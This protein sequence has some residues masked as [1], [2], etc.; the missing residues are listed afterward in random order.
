MTRAGL[1]QAPRRP[2]G[3]TGLSKGRYGRQSRE[4]APQQPC[5]NNLPARTNP[6]RHSHHPTPIAA[7]RQPTADNIETETDP[8]PE[9]RLNP[10]RQ[11]R[12]RDRPHT[13]AAPQPHRGPRKTTSRACPG[14]HV[15]AT[16][17]RP[18]GSCTSGSPRSG[19]HRPSA[20]PVVPG[21]Q[22]AGRSSLARALS[23]SKHRCR[24]AS[25]TCLRAPCP[26]D[27]WLRQVARAPSRTRAGP[28]D[29]VRVT[30][31]SV[32]RAQSCAPR[33][34]GVGPCY[35]V[36]GRR[37]PPTPRATSSRHA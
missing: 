36:R 2:P 19:R 14:G 4:P 3:T 13:R 24:T 37:G 21:G 34:S 18:Q 25:A 28:C 7:Q 20:K 32:A 29:V 9:P 6:T 30:H 1:G 8:R 33:G 31:S 17:A 15:R 10:E 27:T 26:L 11:H 35:V 5:T 12:D 16:Q 22:R 23:S